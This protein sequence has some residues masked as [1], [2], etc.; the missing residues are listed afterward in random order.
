[1]RIFPLNIEIVF[2]SLPTKQYY[3][4]ESSPHKKVRLGLSL[5][6]DSLA[7]GRYSGSATPEPRRWKA[8]FRSALNSLPD[9]QLVKDLGRSTG[10]DASRVYRFTTNGLCE[11]LFGPKV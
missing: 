3:F 5:R 10:R 7:V 1:M 2:H 4:N 9:V 11:I 8:N 6:S